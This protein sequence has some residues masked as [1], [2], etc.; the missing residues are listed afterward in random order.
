MF[1][2]IVQEIFNLQTKYV[3]IN[4]NKAKYMQNNN[5]Y[6]YYNIII[7][8]IVYITKLNN[9]YNAKTITI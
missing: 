2:Y 3:K 4:V 6:V 1:V 9:V 8:N 7:Q 5:R